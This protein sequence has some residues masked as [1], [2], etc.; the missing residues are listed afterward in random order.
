[1]EID[2][3]NYSALKKYVIVR[4]KQK[5]STYW[6]SYNENHEILTTLDY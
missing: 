5:V 2:I 4:V 1:M 6:Y 3:M